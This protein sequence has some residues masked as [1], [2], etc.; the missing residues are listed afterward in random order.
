MLSFMYSSGKI[1]IPNPTSFEPQSIKHHDFT[2][3]FVWKYF[4][5]LVTSGPL[6]L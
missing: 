4:L 2:V 1:L 6:F 5:L 3:V